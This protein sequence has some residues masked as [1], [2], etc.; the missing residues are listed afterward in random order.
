M[1]GKHKQSECLS[2]I[3]LTLFYNVVIH[4]RDLKVMAK[5]FECSAYGILDTDWQFSSSKNCLQ[6]TNFWRTFTDSWTQSRLIY[7]VTRPDKTDS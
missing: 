5:T 2:S 6:F 3:F 1:G 7:S 4:E